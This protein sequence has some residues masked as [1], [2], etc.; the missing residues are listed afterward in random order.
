[1]ALYMSPATFNVVRYGDI[2]LPGMQSEIFFIL[3]KF[4]TTNPLWQKLTFQNALVQ[5]YNLVRL[6]EN[7]KS[8]FCKTKALFF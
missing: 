2:Y 7:I 3:S 8:V 6:S 1:M 4:F 5:L